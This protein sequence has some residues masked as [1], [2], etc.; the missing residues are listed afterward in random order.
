MPQESNQQIKDRITLAANE[1][2]E[3]LMQLASEL[4]RTPFSGSMMHRALWK[5]IEDLERWQNNS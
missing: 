3:R 4:S 2:K 1:P 5:V